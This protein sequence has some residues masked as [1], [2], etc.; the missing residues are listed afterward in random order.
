M[1]PELMPLVAGDPCWSR[2]SVEVQLSAIAQ[3][4]DAKTEWFLATHSPV[5][6][7]TTSGD[8]LSE[9][10]LFQ[11]LFQSASAEQL[12]VIKGP[13]GAGKS[14]VINWLRLRFEDA[15]SQGEL[16]HEMSARPR[17]VLIRRRSGSLKDALE[18]LVAQLPEHGRFLDDVKTAIAQISDEQARRKLSFEISVVLAG[19]QQRGELPVDLQHLHQLF[20]DIRMSEWMCRANGT[21]DRNIQ[22]LTGGSDAETRET[23]PLFP[24]EEFDPR[25]TRRG[26][27]VD[28]L[29]LDLLEE[30]ESLR[31][32][33]AEIVNSVL[34]EALANVTGIKGQTLHEVFRAI[35]RAMFEAGEELALFVEDVSTMS[36]L[37]EELV[38]A[39][40]PQG[41]TG[42]C[43]M[44]SVL[45]MTL[46]AY[47]RLQENKKDRITLALEIQG[48]LGQA[49]ALADES[50]ADRFVARYLNAL[51][52]GE[53]QTP[54]LAQDR[55]EHAEIRHSACD[56]CQLR[57]KCFDAF[58]S[59]DVG[60]VQ[61]GLY[62]LSRGAAF[63]LLQGVDSSDSSHNPR[64]LLRGVVLPLLEAQSSRASSRSNSF[65]IHLKPRVPTDFA[66]ARNTTLGGWDGTQQ[67]RLSY[68]TWYWT[69][70]AD[71]GTARPLLEPMLPWLGLPA[72]TGE[73]RR[74]PTP[75]KEGSTEPDR[76]PPSAAVGTYTPPPES[77]S[78]KTAPAALE[79]ARQRL[80]I[81]FDQKQQLTKDAEYRGLLLQVVKNS[82]DEDNVRTPSF[83]MQYLASS[84]QS[85][86]TAN[87]QIED[88]QTTQKVGSKARFRF[89][90]D[91]ATYDL[92]SV[93]L[94]FEH[95]GKGSWNFPGGI[96]QQRIY[97]RW[98]S[99][100]RASMLQSYHVVECPP[101]DA[102]CVAAAFLVLAYRFCRRTSLP[103]DT[104]AAVEAL[105][106]F[107]PV[108]PAFMTPAAGKL[109]ADARER[110]HKIRR[111]LLAQISV[112]QGGVR[113]LNFIDSRVLQDALTQQRAVAQLPALVN[114]SVESDYPDVYRLGKSE[115]SRLPEILQQEH[116]AMS[117]VL[118]ELRK[119]AARW[120]IGP[121]EPQEDGDELTRS[122]KIFLQSARAAAKACVSAKQSMGRAELQDRILDLPPAKVGTWVSC[123][124]PAV[125]AEGAGP[126]AMLAMEVGALLKFRDFI[127]EID[128]A[129]QQL[130]RDVEDQM[131]QVITPAEVEAER[132]RAHEAVLR[133]MTVIDPVSKSQS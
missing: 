98:L 81:W 96:T 12:I 26:H 79:Q 36:I 84:G 39:L 67:N 63:R 95:L 85:L 94:D 100:H 93:L 51:R 76:T 66:E 126:D 75:K 53:T 104:A 58:S 74:P 46:P 73:S 118:E 42:L 18:Q 6:C 23:L 129:M 80:Q 29:M 3:V 117:A 108:E 120:A 132:E 131:A 125:A 57:G 41:E 10:E 71:I 52:A 61:V 45:G 15:F 35:R 19:M 56:G 33:A 133:L 122:M 121:D 106:S 114:P 13:P 72:F 40:E 54:L 44:L 22:R 70:Q 5:H 97:A 115:W 91:Q 90:R 31:V 55:R 116:A 60:E 105:T 28:T 65:G 49:G 27:D 86:T 47:N 25:G 8:L 124:P 34:R 14:Q 113:S 92:L 43:R 1:N 87:I 77:T 107:E 123:L 128:Q 78:I 16:R 37:D 30:E 88:M 64:G 82:L 102:H 112:P 50:Q 9:A 111:F 83:A 130:A 89:N 11:K 17:T 127:R 68:L 119:V 7:R 48:D 4:S 59:V 103:S 20:Q 32:Q 38:N 21:I 110:V 24:P 2:A 62:P 99:Q 69:G 109:A 101:E